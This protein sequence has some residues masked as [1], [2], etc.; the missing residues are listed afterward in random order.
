MSGTFTRTSVESSLNT[1]GFMCSRSHIRDLPVLENGEPPVC[2]PP[3]G[4]PSGVF[5]SRVMSPEEIRLGN[6]Y[7]LKG[8]TRWWNLS[9]MHIYNT[10]FNVS[11][12][13]TL[14]YK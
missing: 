14:M 13:Q 4:F 7:N 12:S 11:N 3:V 6:N 8:R 5:V 2:R 1:P 10:G 9:E